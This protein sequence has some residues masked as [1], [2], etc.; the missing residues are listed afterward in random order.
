MIKKLILRVNEYHDSMMLMQINHRVAALEGVSKAAILMATVPNKRILENFG[1]AS[2]E[3]ESATPGDMVIGLQT[4]NEQK[5]DEALELIDRLLVEKARTKSRGK[6]FGTQEAAAAANPDTNLV[7]I[8][9]PGQF[10]AREARQALSMD[11]HVFIFSDNVPL[12]DEIELKQ[13]ARQKGLLVMG[14]DCGTAIIDGIG[15][16]FA[17]RVA[18]GPVGIIGA[19]G[20]GIQELSVLL[21]GMG[22]GVSQ[23]IGLGGRDLSDGVGGSSCFTAL[24]LLNQDQATECLVI[25]SK[26]PSLRVVK[27]L[28]S[29]AGKAEK[30][31]ILC[32]LGQRLPKG[33]SADLPANVCQVPN[34]EEAAIKASSLM[35]KQIPWRQDGSLT[36][37]RGKVAADRD[38]FQPIQRYLRGLYSG[39]SLCYEAMILAKDRLSPLFSNIPIKGVSALPSGRQSS[40]NTL[41]DLGEDEFTQGRVH[42]MIDP[43]LVADRLIAEAVDPEV[44]VILF[45]MVLGLGAHEDPASV[46]A[47]AVEQ[48]RKQ[49]KADGRHLVFICHVC[50]TDKDPQDAPKQEERLQAAGVIVSAS[51]LQACEL[52]CNIIAGDPS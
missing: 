22:V 9:T 45:D 4:E 28:I 20:S 19:S 41:L 30:P 12:E 2:R 18:P 49:A 10:A 32:F 17:N 33:A 37:R 26:P 36:A 7:L 11:K 6:R 16:G 24:D 43:S 35:K 38:K 34:I 42:P 13:M 23:A 40:H 5:L 1:F 21:H 52:A 48:T 29:R 50:G 14:P 47:P 46:L 25:L 44:A 31:V 51:N 15:L 27:E 8:S 3:V 39:G